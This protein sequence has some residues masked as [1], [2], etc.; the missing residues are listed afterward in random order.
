MNETE[1]KRIV[2]NTHGELPDNSYIMYRVS[3]DNTEILLRKVIEVMVCISRYEE[4]NWLSD[5]EWDIV[6]PIWFTS[7]VKQ[8]DYKSI[9]DNE[10]LWDYGSWIDALKYRGWKWYSSLLLKDSFLILLEVIDIPYIIEPF[11]FLLRECG[12]RTVDMSYEEH[13]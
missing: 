10:E 1:N 2:N 8:R 4:D 11:E 13:M 12:V 3:A 5:E 6:L 7:G 9:I